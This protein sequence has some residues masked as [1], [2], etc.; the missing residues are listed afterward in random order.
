MRGVDKLKK[1]PVAF[2]HELCKSS[3]IFPLLKIWWIFQSFKWPKKFRSSFDELLLTA[4]VVA[5]AVVAAAASGDAVAVAAVDEGVV[6]AAA[7]AV[8]VV[9]AAIDANSK[10]Y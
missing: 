8:A 5:A 10:N 2:M 1:F 4:T 7:T 3:N 9:I 6:A